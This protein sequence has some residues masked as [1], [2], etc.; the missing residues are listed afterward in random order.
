MDG[1]KM[2]NKSIRSSVVVG[3]AFTALSALVGCADLQGDVSRIDDEVS[4]FDETEIAA[5]RLP[6]STGEL[7]GDNIKIENVTA[8]GAG[9]PS[10]S[11]SYELVPEGNALT[12][13]FDRYLIEAPAT[14]TPVVKQLPCNISLRIRTPKN[15]SYAI[16]SFQYYGYANLTSGMKGTLLAD[17]AWTGFGVANTHKTFRYDFPIPYDTTYAL[18]DDIVAR[19]NALSWA[20]CEI[21]SSLQVRSRLMVENANTQRPAVLA[22][23]N[24]DV[25]AQAALRIT[26][27]TGACPPR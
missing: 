23:D 13:T 27:R 22:M 25:R 18:N 8:S 7:S 21:T 12:I 5:Q 19:G 15:L 11:W 2:S 14:S 24:V 9:C 16:T 17:Y 6:P 20:P 26:F 3:F 1:G 4:S 10:N